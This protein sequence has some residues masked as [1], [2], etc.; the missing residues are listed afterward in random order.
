MSMPRTAYEHRLE[1][2]LSSHPKEFSG[3]ESEPML[4][5]REKYNLLGAQRRVESATLH[6]AGQWA[7]HS[8]N[9]VFPGPNM[10]K[11]HA[12][13]PA[14]KRADTTF[15]NNRLDLLDLFLIY[16]FISFFFMY[17]YIT[18]RMD[19]NRTKITWHTTCQRM[20]SDCHEDSSRQSVE[21]S[22]GLRW[23][24]LN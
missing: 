17:F 16:L 10:F 11:M 21:Q 22:R 23:T 18:H 24:N 2:S 13:S 4:A 6:H 19:G 9:W 8:I 14:V 1:L 12:Y 15:A 3:K 20:S 5:L 7:Q